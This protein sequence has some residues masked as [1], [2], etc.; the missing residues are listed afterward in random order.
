M[1]GTKPLRR[2]NGVLLSSCNNAAPLAHVEY[3]ITVGH[4]PFSGQNTSLANQLIYHLAIYADQFKRTASK[5][6][7]A[8][9]SLLRS[10]TESRMRELPCC[11]KLFWLWRFICINQAG[12]KRAK[13]SSASTEKKRKVTHVTFEKWRHEFDKDCKTV[14]WLECESCVE[15]GTKVVRKLKWLKCAVCT[16]FQSSILHKRNFSDNWI[17]GANSVRTRNI[18]DHASSEQH[19]HVMA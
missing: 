9:V 5:I 18:R 3:N 16:K 12:M 13:S 10:Y 1:A 15:V 19:I 6:K 8:I 17:S 2:F 14:T 7:L 11:I 4:R